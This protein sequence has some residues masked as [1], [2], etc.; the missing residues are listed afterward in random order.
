[1]SLT[2]KVSPTLRTSILALLANG[3]QM[4]NAAIEVRLN[5]GVSTRKIQEATQKMTADG[6]LVKSKSGAFTF[7]GIAPKPVA[8]EATGAAA[9]N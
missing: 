8:T 7:Y 2:S 9:G 3:V 1:M 5:Y 6:T 4:S